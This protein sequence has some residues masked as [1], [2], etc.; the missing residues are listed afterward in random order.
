MQTKKFMRDL[1][2]PEDAEEQSVHLNL[3]IEGMKKPGNM[4]PNDPQHLP[5]IQT[6]A[7]Y[8]ANGLITEKNA[9]RLMQLNE[10][11]TPYLSAALDVQRKRRGQIAPVE[12]EGEKEYSPEGDVYRQVKGGPFVKIPVEGGMKL[13]PYVKERHKEYEQKQEDLAKLDHAL[14]QYEGFLKEHGTQVGAGPLAWNPS[15]RKQAQS[16]HAAVQSGVR[17]IDQMGVLQPGELPFTEKFVD[18]AAKL[19]SIG[20][21]EGIQAQISRVRE[22]SRN[23]KEIL[24]TRYK[25]VP[26]VFEPPASKSGRVERLNRLLKKK[27]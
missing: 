12:Y 13:G 2:T 23:Y 27:P 7:E 20:Q 24:A 14:E 5:Q 16:L 9:I 21:A 26:G 15:L 1:P 22:R 19:T 4:D 8:I 17:T 18:N 6:M 25:N 3:W 10:K 11:T